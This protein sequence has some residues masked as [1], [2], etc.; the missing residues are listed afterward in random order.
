MIYQRLTFIFSF[1]HLTMRVIRTLSFLC[2]L[3]GVSAAVSMPGKSN[4][5]EMFLCYPE[6]YVQKNVIS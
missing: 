5:S 6:E 3:L 2:V 1:Q 4:I